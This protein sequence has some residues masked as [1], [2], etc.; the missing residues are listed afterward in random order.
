MKH[1]IKGSSKTVI[2]SLSIA[3]ATAFV[4]TGCGSEEQPQQPAQQEEAKNKFL[5]IEEKEAGK[6]TIVEEM[7]TDGPNKAII[8]DINGTERV[9][10]EEEMIK[11]AEEEMV[12]VNDNTSNLTNPQAGQEDDGLGLGEILLA[13]AAG[14][15]LGSVVGNMLS[16]NSNYQDQQNRYNQ[17]PAQQQRRLGGGS[18]G[19]GTKT[20][21]TK[22]SFF[23][24]G[25]SSSTSSTSTTSTSSKPDLS[26][27]SSSSTSSSSSKSSSF[28]GG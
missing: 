9:L 2:G 4:S 25:S 24:R 18:Y 23:N 16:N 21:P 28:F 13:G 3:V 5:I 11:F 8:R 19:S 7:P 10:S 6:Y 15:L 1:I 27:S 14:A 12:K 26:K 17:S 22:E 20:A